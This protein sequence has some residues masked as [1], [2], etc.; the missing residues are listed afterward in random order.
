MLMLL[1]CWTAGDVPEKLKKKSVEGK[2]VGPDILAAS[3]RRY[4]TNA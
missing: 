3:T 1:L 4:S 2:V